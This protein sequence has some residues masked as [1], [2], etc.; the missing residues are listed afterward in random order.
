M[1]LHDLGSLPF[2]PAFARRR[3]PD[4]LK[5]LRF[6]AEIS[7]VRLLE[8]ALLWNRYDIAEYVVWPARDASAPE[9]RNATG[10][11]PEAA[12]SSG[13]TGRSPVAAAADAAVAATTKPSAA[14]LPKRPLSSEQELRLQRS[15]ALRGEG[16]DQLQGEPAV[17][18]GAVQGEIASLAALHDKR[19]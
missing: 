2:G 6:Q 16:C 8:L 1:C 14:L 3:V 11:V 7:K 4:R 13:L 5:R 19:V 18:D 12:R 9:A 15:C 10:T 17:S